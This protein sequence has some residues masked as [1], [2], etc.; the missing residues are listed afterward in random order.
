MPELDL[1]AIEARYKA[2]T[3]GPWEVSPDIRPDVVSVGLYCNEQ[4]D[5]NTHLVNRVHGFKTICGENHIAEFGK[6]YGQKMPDGT[7]VQSA[8]D[9]AYFIAH[10]RTDIPALVAEVRRLREENRP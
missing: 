7:T 9:D 5:G 10:A 4:P 1:D 8:L 6:N 2:A 3:P